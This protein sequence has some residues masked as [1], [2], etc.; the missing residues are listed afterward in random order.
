MG[1]TFI[2]EPVSLLQ[3]SEG[4]RTKLSTVSDYPLDYNIFL[5]KG[6]SDSRKED[7]QELINFRKSI[8]DSVP[9]DYGNLVFGGLGKKDDGTPKL[10]LTTTARLQERLLKLLILERHKRDIEAL[11][12]M[13]ASD[14]ENKKRINYNEIKEPLKYEIKSPIYRSFESHKALYKNSFKK[15]S[16]LQNV[17]YDFEHVIDE[18]GDYQNDNDLVDAFCTED[19]VGFNE[20]MK[21]NKGKDYDSLEDVVSNSE[22]GRV[23]IPLAAQTF[24]LEDDETTETPELDDEKED[25]KRS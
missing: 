3:L 12:R 16:L 1:A 2:D 21:E 24:I 11:N 7:E 10:E 5:F 6:I 14:P 20:K 23:L 19:I 18:D 15:F 4:S 9:E 13:L 22:I 8:L 25:V 17:E